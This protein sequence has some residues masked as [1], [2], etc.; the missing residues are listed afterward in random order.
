M[1]EQSPEPGIAPV[2]WVPALIVIALAILFIF[3][4]R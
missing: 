4:V 3:A 2:I 1:T